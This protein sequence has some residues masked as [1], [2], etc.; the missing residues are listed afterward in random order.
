MAKTEAPFADWDVTKMWDVS[1]MWG[2]MK[3]PGL[4][5]EA[6]A[7]AQR[8]NMAALNEFNKLAVEGAQAIAKRQAEIAR[9]VFEQSAAAAK[10]LAALGTPQE[11]VLRQAELSKDA[12]EMGL[13]TVREMSEMVARATDKTVDVMRTRYAEGIDELRAM[14]A[15]AVR[16]AGTKA[17]S[18]AASP[19]EK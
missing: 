19:V 15:G 1:K 4:D 10:D 18:K 3:M 6:F 14:V 9:D 5:L 11:R 2:E 17:A 7:A 16:P 13:E 8:R 12:F